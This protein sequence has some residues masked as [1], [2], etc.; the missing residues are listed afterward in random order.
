MVMRDIAGKV[1]LNVGI[2][3]D[4]KFQKTTQLTKSGKPVA[5]ISFVGI[6]DEERGGETLTIVCAA[7]CHD[8]FHRKLIEM[9]T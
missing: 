2:S 8:D 5:K 1:T 9:S 4:T 6:R 7:Q 3:K